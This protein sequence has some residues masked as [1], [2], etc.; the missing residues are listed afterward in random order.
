VDKED[1]SRAKNDDA[2]GADAKGVDAVERALTI[3]NAFGSTGKTSLSLHELA[4]ATGFYKSTILRLA[5]S[6]ERFAYLRR[7]EDGRFQPGP[8]CAALAA[9]QVAAVDKAELLQRTV[10]HLAQE[11]GET[12]SYYVAEGD[13][14]V[15]VFREN[16][17]HSIR[18]HLE[19]GQ[20]LP[21]ERGAAGLVLSAFAGKPG[22]RMDQVRA[23]GLSTSIGEREPD[24]AGVSAPVFDTTGRVMGALTISGL[25]SRFTPAAIRRYR[26]L[27]QDAVDNLDREFGLA[28]GARDGFLA[29]ATSHKTARR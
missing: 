17:A 12:S 28:P 20:R 24:A 19:I 26:R 9:M 5:V 13:G 27:M 29:A 25:R 23:E 18:H 22:A 4:E 15:C 14:R 11:S 6:L 2:R 16:S 1:S 7:R 8:A 10:K 3:L 21:L